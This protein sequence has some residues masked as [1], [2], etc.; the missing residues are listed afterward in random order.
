M[1]KREAANG[2]ARSA[3]VSTAIAAGS[4]GK[5]FRCLLTPLGRVDGA[6]FA[7]G[8]TRAA[9][10]VP[11]GRAPSARPSHGAAAAVARLPRAT[12][13]RALTKNGN[14]GI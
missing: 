3:L 11:A 8:P 2:S 13:L 10:G 5:M 12:D 6:H 1:A 4:R 7:R 14:P 9:R